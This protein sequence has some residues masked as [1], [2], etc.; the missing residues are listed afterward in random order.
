MQAIINACNQQKIDAEVSIVV[1]DNKEAKG[2]EYL[3]NLNIESL[4]LNPKEFRS[5]KEYE[6]TIIKTLDEL[7]VDLICLAG[8]MRLIG[9]TLLESYKNKIINI[10]PSLLPSFKGLNPQQQAIHCGVKY[11]GATVHF[12][13]EELDSGSIIDQEIVPVHEDDTEELLSQRI[14]EIEHKLYPRAIGKV[15]KKISEGVKI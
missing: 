5:K 4:A 9:P 15:L 1:A 13:N 7:K 10:H 11:S 6:T 12:V 2:L 14:L 8:Y 3:Q